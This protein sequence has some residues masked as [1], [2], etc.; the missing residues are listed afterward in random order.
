MGT[1]KPM[2]LRNGPHS[3]LSRSLCAV[4]SVSTTWDGCH[5]DKGMV[6]PG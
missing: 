5:R 1:H 6:F 3:M 4:R 2:L